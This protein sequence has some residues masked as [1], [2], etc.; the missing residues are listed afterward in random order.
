MTKLLDHL[1]ALNCRRTFGFF[2]DF[3]Q[4]VTGDRWTLVASDSGTATNSD[5]HAGVLALTPSDGTVADNDEIYLRSTK[6]LFLLADDKPIIF[7]ARI[8]YAEGNTDDANVCFGMMNAVAADSILDNGGGPKASY[9][10]FVFFKVDGGTVWN[11]ESSNGASQVTTVTDKTAGGS[12]YKTFR[13]E[14]QPVN[15]TSAEVSF[16][17]EGEL[18][19]K[20]TLSLTSLTEMHVF[21]GMK[22]GA[23]TTVETLNI[24]YIA[25]YGLR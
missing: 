24:D 21:A 14:A 7:E 18:V 23:G 8:Q 16:Y 1:P 4:Y 20:H 5:A 25:A 2:D 12:A 22:N 13:I 10:G 19:A 15:S 6:E 9:S 3:D 17:F 11:C